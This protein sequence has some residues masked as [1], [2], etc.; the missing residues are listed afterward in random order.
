MMWTAQGTSENRC[1]RK[2]TEML[3]YII[4][5]QTGGSMSVTDVEVEEDDFLVRLG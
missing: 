5:L 4:I 2:S 1:A 3:C